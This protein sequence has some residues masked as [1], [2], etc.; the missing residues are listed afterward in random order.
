MSDSRIK[1]CVRARPS[2]TSC[3]SYHGGNALS[4][5]SKSF[6]FDNV[7][8]PSSNTEE[9]YSTSAAKDI[10]TAVA[11]H[12]VDGTVFLYGQ[13]GSGK[14]HSCFGD[15]RSPGLIKLAL[16]DMYAITEA[17]KEN[18]DDNHP[19]LTFYEIF[20]ERV[21][22]LLA[23]PP[24]RGKTRP[25]LPVRVHP[26]GHA[27]IEGITKV[28]IPSLTKALSAIG[29][30]IAARS[31]GSTEM[32]AQ[33]SRSHAV[34][35][36]QLSNSSSAH[37]TFVDLAGSER[38]RDT[39]SS[40][41]R[42]KE[43]GM[44]NKSLSTLG[45]VIFALGA[46]SASADARHVP[47][48]DS[49]LTTLLRGSLSPRDCLTVMI[50]CIS[51]SPAAFDETVSTLKF[52]KR[53]KLIRCDPNLIP[54]STGSSEVS[55]L[56][57]E[58]ARLR[59]QMSTAT[60]KASPDLLGKYQSLDSTAR[61]IHELSTNQRFQQDLIIKF[62]DEHIKR[63]Q[64]R[65]EGT[66]D[67][68]PDSDLNVLC[69]EID[70]L[71]AQV[72]LL[73]DKDLHAY[74]KFANN[75]N[76]ADMK[77]QVEE[78]VKE[79]AALTEEVATLKSVN[80]EGPS[81]HEVQRQLKEFREKVEDFEESLSAANSTIY[82][83]DET[84][85]ELKSQLQQSNKN[86]DKLTHEI[87]HLQSELEEAKRANESLTTEHEAKM[88]DLQTKLFESSEKMANDTSELDLKLK[89]AS[90]SK[91]NAVLQ[92]KLASRQKELVEV[93]ES[94]E[95]V[96]VEKE[97]INTERMENLER[98]MGEAWERAGLW[99]RA[100]EDSER[101]VKN[102]SEEVRKLIKKRGDDA[103]ELENLQEDM[104]TMT[105]QVKFLQ[106]KNQELQEENARL[107]EN[108]AI[109]IG[110]RG[111]IGAENLKN[112]QIDG[113]QGRD[114]AVVA[115]GEEEDPE[116]DEDEETRRLLDQVLFQPS[117]AEQ[118]AKI[119][120]KDSKSEEERAGTGDENDDSM[121]FEGATPAK[122]SSAR[123]SSRSSILEVR[124]MNIV[125]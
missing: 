38:Q 44:I 54:T 4:I 7:L 119:R 21:Y 94:H 30:G 49:R 50:M 82:T 80:V 45:S 66:P 67:P 71:R 115:W 92:T 1:V 59:M 95:R 83:R 17:N 14:T 13:T 120:D 89:V 8:S 2:S 73:G 70:S 69:R 98:E 99:E 111:D 48:R 122:Q 19:T 29:A 65:L 58:I 35:R 112:S 60:P 104:D 97:K 11:T 9:L 52:A 123:R 34:V 76:L 46:N 102:L 28:P 79:N 37:L 36:I 18:P 41:S 125:S 105:E 23:P 109:G 78:I 10:T 101:R 100:A 116:E 57:R 106:V 87:R 64:S 47:Y 5:N 61:T 85:A 26:S 118:L 117:V 56:K 74:K 124:D 86:A 90:I 3:I 55:D 62:K 88:E 25:S 20:Q 63:L 15:K 93:K 16:K 84:I 27:R 43:A 96:T 72:R 110:G 108:E 103:F 81:N 68:D 40:G 114:G 42:L 6:T 22:D 107:I 113:V 91:D 53:V 77:Q 24:P 51:P 32:N 121:Y 12:G 39:K 33:S 75:S 31:T